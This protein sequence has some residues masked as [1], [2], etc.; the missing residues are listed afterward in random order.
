VR[1]HLLE[2]TGDHAG[3]IRHFRLAAE[4][5]TSVAERNYLLSQAARLGERSE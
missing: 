2:R 5:T 1:A 3:A 4:R